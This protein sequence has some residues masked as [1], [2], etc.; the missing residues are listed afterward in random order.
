LTC[1]LEFDEY[2]ILDKKTK[3]KFGTVAHHSE[4][5]LDYVHI[6]IWGPTKIASLGGHQYFVS[7]IYDVSRCCWVYFMRQKFEV[8]DLF[9]KM[10]KLMVKKNGRKIKVLQFDYVGE[11]KDRFLKFDQNNSIDIHFT[12]GKQ[13][14]VKEMNHFLLEKI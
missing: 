5:L 9:M 14:L 4:G 8:L 11:N 1:S 13:V 3:V 12:V 2:C 6:N 10:K 7:F